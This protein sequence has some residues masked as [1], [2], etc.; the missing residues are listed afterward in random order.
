M[1]SPA[2]VTWVNGQPHDIDPVAA[3]FNDAWFSQALHMTLAAFEATGFAVAGI[4]ALRLLQKP[5]SELH[6]RGLRIALT[7]GAVAA[8]LQPLSGDH[9]AKDVAQRQPAKLA[10]MEAHYHTERGAG[11]I[12]GGWPDDQT[13]EVRY[14]VEIPYALSILAF[15]DPHAEV[16]G[17]DQI[18]E[19][20]RAPTL[21]CHLAFQ[22]MVGAGTLLAGVAIL[23]F[24]A[25]RYRKAWLGHPRFLRLLVALTP[26]GFIAVE[27]GWTVTEVGR[28]PWIIY[29][30]M[31]T[32]DAVSPMPG[33]AASFAGTCI[34]YAL[35]G[36]IALAVLWR[37]IVT[38]ENEQEGAHG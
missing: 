4:H 5:A 35:L 6:A 13:Q 19:N 15:G 11:L 31:R 3:M 29:G 9:S 2:G 27:A 38:L 34:I 23:F 21:I 37:M 30:V 28:Q 33:L 1:N 18:P 17:L 7:M 26:L 25:Q 32:A 8:L 10:A 22:V 16:K 24:W 12:V 36:T 14:A 20:E